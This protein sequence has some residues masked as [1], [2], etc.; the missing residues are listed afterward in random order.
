M[1]T[2]KITDIL[3]VEGI[4]SQGF[5][6]SP[7]IVMRDKRLTVEAKA[8]Y[9][10][11]ASFAGAGSQ[12][13]PGRDLMLEKLDISPKRYYK[14]L[15]LLIECD[16]LRIDREV[17]EHGWKGRNIYTLVAHPDSDY[18][19]PESLQTDRPQQ[20]Q[21]SCTDNR[22]S[23]KKEEKILPEIKKHINH[24]K[25]KNPLRA[26]L[27]IDNLI[28]NDP[29]SGK[30]IEMIYMAADDM[31]KCEELKIGNAIKRKEDLQEVVDSL[32]ADNIRIV[33]KALQ[34]NNFN[35]KNRRKYIQT[36]LFN[37]IYDDSQT[38]IEEM[39]LAKIRAAEK[40]SKE[41]AEQKRKEI[42][43]A[44]P[45]LKQMDEEASDIAIKLCRMTFTGSADEKS[46]LKAKR[47]E[48]E[49]SMKMFCIREGIDAELLELNA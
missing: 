16:Y 37:S 1:E 32:T 49:N 22:N 8:I 12:A 11:I 10:Y 34:D 35:I 7:K 33:L 4:M 20:M 28:K 47:N 14:H 31:T 36:C 21:L 19:K 17:D 27:D 2:K 18:T 44:Y 41:S 23:G 25:R 39:E 5:G 26:Q 48:I 38:I 30:D 24:P 46:A 43:A 40:E 6:L 15:Q 13:F 45:E 3:K 9:S 29:A 42:F